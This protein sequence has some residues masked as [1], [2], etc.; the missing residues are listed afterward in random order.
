[1]RLYDAQPHLNQRRDGS[2][3]VAKA[4]L[5]FNPKTTG[6]SD[7]LGERPQMVFVQAPKLVTASVS[8]PA[9]AF[10]LAFMLA[11][12][13]CIMAAP[14][15]VII[16]CGVKGDGPVWA[17]ELIAAHAACLTFVA[18]SPVKETCQ[19]TADAIRLRGVR[20]GSGRRGRRWHLCPVV[21][22]TDDST[23]LQHLRRRWG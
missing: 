21:G 14:E 9:A 17:T 6:V 12:P 1:M 10:M 2:A 15:V 20:Y 7:R 4:V 18:M 16:L 22:L 5:V 8:A 13:E 11:V 3:Q 19:F 23:G